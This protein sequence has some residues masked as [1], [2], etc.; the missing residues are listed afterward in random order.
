MSI[1]NFLYTLPE[2]ELSLWHDG[3]VFSP[4]KM[5]ACRSETAAGGAACRDMIASES[6]PKC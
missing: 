5:L 2:E 6:S 1:N 4:V 3:V